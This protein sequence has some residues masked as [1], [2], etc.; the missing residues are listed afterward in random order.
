MSKAKKKRSK[1]Y[2][3]VNA[4]T[5]TRPTVTRYTAVVRSPLGQWWQDKGRGW[6][7]IVAIGLGAIVAIWLIVEAFRTIFH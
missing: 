1:S 2:Q 6:A 3:G 5:D 7:K 4:A